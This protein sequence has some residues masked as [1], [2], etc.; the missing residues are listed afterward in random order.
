MVTA[1][2]LQL[3]NF[4]REFKVAINASEVLVGAIL[5]QDFGQGLQPICY[6]IRKLNPVECKYSACEREL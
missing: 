1:S 6:D 2:V 4:D 3:P 5:Q